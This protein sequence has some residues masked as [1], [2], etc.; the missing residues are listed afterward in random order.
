[1]VKGA[2]VR[3]SV[4][5][6]AKPAVKPPWCAAREEAVREEEKATAAPREASPPEE[7]V[8]L[9]TSYAVLL[10]QGW[11]KTKKRFTYPLLDLTLSRKQVRERIKRTQSW[12][13]AT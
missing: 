11:T 13:W 6:A 2:E 5:R 9:A 7:E 10:A 12:Q 1:M 3:E 8:D 4:Q